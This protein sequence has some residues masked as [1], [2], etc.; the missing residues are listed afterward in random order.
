M[1]QLLQLQVLSRLASG[2]LQNTARRLL[3]DV[4]G[5]NK[6]TNDPLLITPKKEVIQLTAPLLFQE[7]AASL[8][9]FDTQ[10]FLLDAKGTR[11]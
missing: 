7:K 6:Q 3:V 2:K 4:C 5:F 1:L 9:A 8:L 11:A 10:M